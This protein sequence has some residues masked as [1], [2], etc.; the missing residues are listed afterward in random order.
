MFTEEEDSK[1][2]SIILTTLAAKSYSGEQ[3]IYSAL[4]NI[5]E[6]MGKL[7][8]SSTPRVPNP[9]DPGEDFADRW[10]MPKY[11]HLKLEENFWSWLEQAKND[12]SILENS[13]QPEFISKQASAKFGIRLDERVLA[14][15][16]GIVSSPSVITSP[17]RHEVRDENKPWRSEG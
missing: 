8:N 13:T 2:I 10:S 15:G 14:K 17:K 5:L 6:K 11:R 1:P 4:T 12:L 16:L 7:V 9:V 3:D